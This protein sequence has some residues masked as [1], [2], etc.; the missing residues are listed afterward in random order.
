MRSVLIS[1]LILVTFLLSATVYAG[2]KEESRKHLKEGTALFKSGQYER[3][4][5][6]YEKSYE[7]NPVYSTQR[8]IALAEV[9]LH[10]Y[11]RAIKAYE[12]FLEQGGD[13]VSDSRRKKTGKEINRLHNILVEKERRESSLKKADA[14]FKDGIKLQKMGKLKEARTKFRTSY[15]LFPNNEVLFHLGMAESRLGLNDDAHETLSLYL[16]EGVSSTPPKNRSAAER[17]IRRLEAIVSQA[18][19]RKKGLAKFEEGRSFYV[20][21]QFARAALAFDKAYEL[22]KDYKFLY[23]IAKTASQLGDNKKALGAYRRFLKDGGTSV[24]GRQRAEINQEIARLTPIVNKDTVKD[25]SRD[26]FKKGIELH[27]DGKYEAA[28]RKLEQAYKLDPSYKILY[29]L[30]QAQAE[31]KKYERAL[32]TYRR[33][34]DKGG[35]E[36]PK[37]RRG[38]V[39]RQIEWLTVV[40]SNKANKK[41]SDALFKKGRELKKQ[42]QYKAA[43][44]KFEEAHELYKNYKIHYSIGLV[45][46]E[47]E[48]NRKALAAYRNYLAE[49][50]SK[51]PENRRAKVQRKIDSLKKTQNETATKK[52]SREHFDKGL[53]AKKTGRHDK[54]R[55]ELEIAYGLYPN[56][57]ILLAMARNEALAENDDEALKKYYRFLKEGGDEISTKKRAKVQKEIDRIAKTKMRNEN[58]ARADRHFEKGVRLKKK[59]KWSAAIYELEQAQKFN[60]D[61]DVLY[62]LAGA[63]AG[64]KNNA[65]ALKYYDRF[66]SKGGG[67]ISKKRRAEVKKEISRLYPLVGHIELECRVRGADIEVDNKVEGKTPLTKSIFVDAGKHKVVVTKDGKE[68]MRKKVRLKA[69]ERITLQVQTNL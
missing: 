45:A 44:K 2:D 57:K 67:K 58:K 31:A 1:P 33:Y 63:H 13:K 16:A 53:A 9:E 28:T 20:K 32:S 30:A 12:R 49:G 60:S 59:R 48:Q 8:K 34:L 6:E 54:A 4:V 39:K 27:N 15:D 65:F 43:L 22:L 24:A 69:G 41:K 52:Q 64:L 55:S 56:Y 10:N 62:H 11:D 21:G 40:E 19:N 51:I 66:L 5:I 42:R 25:R 37:K 17:E 18:A 68:L 47:L 29:N 14:F 35:R 3:A 61:Y 38:E 7:L 36:I 26:A 50:G 46:T 23:D